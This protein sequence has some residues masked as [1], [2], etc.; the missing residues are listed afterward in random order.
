MGSCSKQIPR[1]PG[2]P[3]STKVFIRELIEIDM[4]FIHFSDGVPYVRDSVYK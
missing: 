3:T 2:R 4:S 1:L